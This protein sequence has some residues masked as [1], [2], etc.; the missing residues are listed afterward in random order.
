MSVFGIDLQRISLG[1]L[2]IALTLLV[3]DAM[4]TVDAMLRRLGAGDTPDQAATFAYRTLAAPMLIGTLVTIAAF[5]PIGFAAELGR[6]I[7]LLDLL[8]GRHLADRLLAGGG[9]LRA[10][11]RQGA[12]QATEEAGDREPSRASWC[13]AIAASCKGRSA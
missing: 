4:T 9:G 3:D 13:A 1:A 10:A 6:R 7:H 2:I 11:A 5:V 8:G 12:A